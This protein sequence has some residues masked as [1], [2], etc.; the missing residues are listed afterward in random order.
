MRKN[1]FPLAFMDQ[2]F[3]RLVGQAYYYFLGEYSTYIQIVVD[4]EIKIILLSHPHLE[5]LLM[6][7]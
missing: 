2:I 5:Y 7:I 4:H 1:Q 3:E 6:K